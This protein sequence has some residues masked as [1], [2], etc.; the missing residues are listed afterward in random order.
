MHVLGIGGQM[1]RIYDP[2]QYQFLVN[3]QPVNVFITWAAFILGAAQI[4]FLVNFFWSIFAGRRTSERNPWHATTLE[5]TATTSPP[6][7]HGNFETPPEVFHG[8]YEYSVPG[9]AQDYLPQNQKD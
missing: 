7:A 5:W 8:P 2:T 9:R 1:R 3:Q 6:L 4:I